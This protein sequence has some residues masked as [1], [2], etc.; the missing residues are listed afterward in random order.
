M[1]VT[2][3]VS[4]QQVAGYQEITWI[5]V[6]AFREASIHNVAFTLAQIYAKYGCKWK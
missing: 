6:L 3:N 2:M 4:Y 5:Y 1:M